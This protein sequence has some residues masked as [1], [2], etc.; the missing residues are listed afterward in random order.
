MK[1]RRLRSPRFAYGRKLWTSAPRSASQAF[2][3]PSRC[4]GNNGK[5]QLVL[6]HWFYGRIWGADCLPPGNHPHYRR[7]IHN[8]GSRR[9]PVRSNDP[10]KRV[11]FRIGGRIF[12]GQC[13]KTHRFRPN[14]SHGGAATDTEEGGGTTLPV[15]SGS[16]T[17]RS[18]KDEKRSGGNRAN[19]RSRH[20]SGQCNEGRDSTAE[21][22]S[23]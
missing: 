13:W 2:R 5:G 18:S 19:G 10:A 15:G 7:P 23:P 17:C 1:A 22:G 16:R 12:E 3:G 9:E 14:T 20:A 4:A 8:S 11:S 21:A 6:P